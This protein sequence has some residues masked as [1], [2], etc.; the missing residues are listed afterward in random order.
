MDKKLNRIIELANAE[1]GD[2]LVA[3]NFSPLDAAS[4]DDAHAGDTLATFIAQELCDLCSGDDSVSMEE[5]LMVGQ[6]GMHKAA[7]QLLDV[8]DALWHELTK[9]MEKQ[10]GAKHDNT[11]PATADCD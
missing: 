11:L 5:R 4:R 6:A 3:A 8:S 9:R 7:Q 1:Y 2:G 10:Y